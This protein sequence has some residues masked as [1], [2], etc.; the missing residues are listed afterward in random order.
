MYSRINVTLTIKN[1][2]Y[3]FKELKE[4]LIA[5]TSGKLE[6]FN[7]IYPTPKGLLGGDLS[8]PLSQCMDLLRNTSKATLDES[9]ND[10]EA[11]DPQIF[12]SS[13]K[14][15]EKEVIKQNTHSWRINN[16]GTPSEA[17]NI[18]IQH[19]NECEFAA[20][21]DVVI[22]PPWKVLIAI[23]ERFPQLT[24]AIEFSSFENDYFAAGG[25]APD[26]PIQLDCQAPFFSPYRSSLPINPI[27]LS[28]Q[29]IEFGKRFSKFPITCLLR[30][31]NGDYVESTSL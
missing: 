20:R 29:F 31:L 22:S 5:A 9:I 8:D 11:F 17:F 28:D 15:A 23:T 26:M 12:K 4:L 2:G 19:I 21:F 18:K 10:Q 7:S 13:R 1:T 3:G 24:I 27:S 6:L 14:Y 30:D 16:W 25:Y